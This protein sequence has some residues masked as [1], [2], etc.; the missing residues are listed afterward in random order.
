MPS[1]HSPQRLVQLAVLL[2]V[3]LPRLATAAEVRAAVAA[4]FA[5][6]L[7]ELA[8]LFHKQT[9]HTVVTTPGS[10]GKLATQIRQG[11]PFDV[12]LAADE[13]APA[14]LEAEGLAVKGSRFVY[15]VGRLVLWSPD[16]ALLDAQATALREGRFAKLAIADPK[17]APYGLAAQ[18][19][20][21]K[22][23]LWSAVEPK[24]VRGESVQQAYQFAATGN[25]QLA[26]VSR[27]QVTV[28]GALRGG[29]SWTVP[30]A[31]HAPIRRAAVLL[32]SARDRAAANAFL[33]F[34]RAPKTLDLLRQTG[35]EPPTGK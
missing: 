18:E 2:L 20:L 9:G 14:A 11:A 23:G 29:S 32:T 8:E 12:F 1:P 25:A 28:R 33:Q 15:A 21:T 13:A 24:L 17:L 3:A 30:S 31:L 19:A 4:N 10:T 26:F 6:P 34:L 27:A 16:A 5:A 35:Y 7:A 22:L